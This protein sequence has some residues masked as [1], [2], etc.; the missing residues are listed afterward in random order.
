MGL[1]GII[2][3]F[4]ALQKLQLFPTRVHVTNEVSNDLSSTIELEQKYCK[5]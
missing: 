3:A 5:K 4:L 2:G 1:I